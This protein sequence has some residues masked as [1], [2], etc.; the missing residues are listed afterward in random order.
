MLRITIT[1]TETN[2]VLEDT[3]AEAVTGISVTEKK[4]GENTKITGKNF[5]VGN[6]SPAVLLQAHQQH[7]DKI[8]GLITGISKQE[9]QI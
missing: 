1:D 5:T 7:G 2:E 3:E 8:I 9:V 6:I 4:E